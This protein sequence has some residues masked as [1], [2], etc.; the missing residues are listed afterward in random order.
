MMRPAV[1]LDLAL[2]LVT[3]LAYMKFTRDDRPRK[4]TPN[5]SCQYC[6][7]PI[8][9]GLTKCPRCSDFYDKLHSN[10]LTEIDPN[11]QIRVTYTVVDHYAQEEA[12]GQYTRLFQCPRIFSGH[13][14]A[15]NNLIDARYFQRETEAR[16]NECQRTYE[17]V[18]AVRIET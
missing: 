6:R 15:Q 3:W 18:S 12:V 9:G 1:C 13:F 16:D 11:Y 5:S 10:S 7:R 2:A 17:I 14:D 8:R 4:R